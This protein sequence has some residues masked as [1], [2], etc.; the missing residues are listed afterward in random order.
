[1]RSPDY[2][3]QAKW[4][5]QVKEEYHKALAMSPKSRKKP[6]QQAANMA[7]VKAE[8]LAEIEKTASEASPKPDQEK[9]PE[10]KKDATAKG[11]RERSPSPPGGKDKG[12][13]KK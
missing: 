11:G 8:R 4:K 7:A 10:E 12:A 2:V 1:M 3:V 13:K 5:A 9:P 6:A